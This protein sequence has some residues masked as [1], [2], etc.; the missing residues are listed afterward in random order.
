[1]SRPIAASR[2]PSKIKPGPP[3][4]WPLRFDTLVQPVLDKHCVSCHQPGGN[5]K[6]AAR[7]DLTPAAAYD[8]LTAYGGLRQQVYGK[9]TAGRS[10]PGAVI[11]ADS[12]LVKHL[13]AGHQ[14]VKLEQDD[15][16]R[17]FTWLD[18]Y[19]QRLGSF[20]PDQEQHLTELKTKWKDLLDE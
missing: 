5:E 13:R 3:G 10:I 17:L 6:A 18:T 19:A 1:M 7:L 8:S 14:N 2:P 12:Q 16:E 15:W 20:S 4:S 9:Y 11:A